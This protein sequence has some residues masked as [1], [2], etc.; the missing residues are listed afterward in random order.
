MYGNDVNYK[1][2]LLFFNYCDQLNCYG[3][4]FYSGYP[5]DQIYYLY[6]LK[7]VFSIVYSCIYFY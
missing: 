3:C 4:Y 1:G 7:Q 6:F 2:L 5:L